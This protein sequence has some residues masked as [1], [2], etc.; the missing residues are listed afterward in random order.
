MKITSKTNKTIIKFIFQFFF[1]N[2]VYI[3]IKIKELTWFNQGNYGGWRAHK[4]LHEEEIKSSSTKID[5]PM[6]HEVVVL[7]NGECM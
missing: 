5:T 7:W 6:L 1:F 3:S 4:T 2:K